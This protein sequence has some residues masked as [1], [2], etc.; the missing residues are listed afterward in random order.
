MTVDKGGARCAARTKSVLQGGE[1][2]N[3]IAAALRLRGVN[4]RPARCEER[5]T[6]ITGG[7]A[8]LYENKGVDKKATHKVMK[9]KE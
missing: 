2:A 7:N 6:K 5:K 3:W 9:T 8:D 4:L 1:A